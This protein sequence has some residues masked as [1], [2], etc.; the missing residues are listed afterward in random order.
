VARITAVTD[1]AAPASRAWQLVTDW[2]SHGRWVPLTTVRVIEAG[3]GGRGV[4]TRFVGRTGLGPIGFDDPMTV[5]AFV[6]PSG[7]L[8]GDAVGRC[9]VDKLGEVVRGTAWFE[10]QPVDSHRC[11]ITWG[12]DVEIA[13]RALTRLLRPWVEAG[14]RQGLRSVLRSFARDAA[15]G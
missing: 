7:D 10:V 12:E 11:R 15:R 6:P 14:G 8:H 1:V 13:P 5:T 4:G 2:P 9:D 3:A